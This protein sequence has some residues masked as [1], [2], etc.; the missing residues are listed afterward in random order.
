M[1][2]LENHP[3][4]DTIKKWIE[5]EKIDTCTLNEV[6]QKALGRTTDIIKDENWHTLHDVHKVCA[7]AGLKKTIVRLNNKSCRV[8][9]TNN[10]NKSAL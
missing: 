1:Q 5:R 9:T 3:A 2:N 4:V 7:F 10:K 6:W 8:L